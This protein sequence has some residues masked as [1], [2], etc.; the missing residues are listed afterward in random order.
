MSSHHI[1]RENQEPA[2]L[3]EDFAALSEEYLGQLLEWSPT[4]ITSLENLDYFL[5]RDIKV[6]ILY[7]VEKIS[8]AQEEIKYLPGTANFWKDTL[9]Y[10]VENKY[11]AVNIMAHALQEDF[12]IAAEAINSVV[13]VKNVRYVIVRSRYEKWKTAGQKMFIDPAQVKSFNG[14]KYISDTIFE[15]EQEGFVHIEMNSDKFIFVGEE[16]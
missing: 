6:D 13:F 5:T 15:V 11:K 7:G 14:L 4:I 8:E 1:V 9:A 16:I 2:L 3:V 10:L 12:L